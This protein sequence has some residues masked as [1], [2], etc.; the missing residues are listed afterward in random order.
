MSL[1]TDAD[2]DTLLALLSSLLPPPA[3][4]QDQLLNALVEAEGNVDEA[5][6]R[7]TRSVSSK[8]GQKRS[9]TAWLDDWLTR[10]SAPTSKV[11]RTERNAVEETAQESG[12]TTSGCSPRPRGKSPVKL[13]VNLMSVL[14]QP[15]SA[16]QSILRLPPMM[17]SNSSLVAQHTPCTLHPSVLPPELACHLFYTMVDASQNWQR[18]KWW[19]FDRLVESPHRTSFFARKTDGVDSDESW[20]EAAQYW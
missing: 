9:R 12:A 2:T 1:E 14:R 8:Q 16:P 4:G 3:F 10:G 19:L 7:L 11:A 6:R 20:Q 5:A 17:L 13:V 18:N 15:P